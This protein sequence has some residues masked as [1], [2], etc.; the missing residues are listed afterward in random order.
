MSLTQ[1]A[2]EVSNTFWAEVMVAMA[3]YDRSISAEVDDISRHSVWFLNYT[4]FKNGEIKSWKGREIV[5]INDLLKE[6]GDIFHFMRQ[7]TYISLVRRR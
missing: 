2:K 1:L 6:N 7:R 5:Y 4:K 3:Q